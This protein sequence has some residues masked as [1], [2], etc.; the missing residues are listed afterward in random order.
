MR[1]RINLNRMVLTLLTLLL[2]W[3]LETSTGY[4]AQVDRK[5]AIA[6]ADLWYAMEINAEHTRM[7][8][9]EKAAR[10]SNIGSRDLL[11]LVSRDELRM[12][13]PKKEKVLAYIVKYK[14]NGFVVVSGE[15]R[16]K[17][18]LVFNAE[19]EFSFDPPERNY[20]RRYLEIALIG[21]FELLSKKLEDKIPVGVHANWAYL[22]AKVRESKN[23]ANASF[24]AGT[25][26]RGTYVLWDTASW[27]QP[28]PYNETV[29][30]NNGNI[31]GIPTGCNA[32]AMAI[33]MRFHE[34]PPS[35]N[36]DH[37][38]TDTV[39]YNNQLY[40]FNHYVN[41]GDQTYDWSEMPTGNVTQSNL[42]VA[43][44]MYHSG[45]CVDMNYEIPSSNTFFN[46]PNF[47]KHFRYKGTTKVTSNHEPGLIES[48]VAG[49]PVHTGNAPHAMLTTGYRD[50]PWPYF[51]INPGFNGSGNDW[52][53]LSAL[54]GGPSPITE[55]YPY[56]APQN[57]VYVREDYTG[58]ENGYPQYPF[59]TLVEGNNAVPEGGK[60][61][62]RQGTYEGNGNTPIVFSKAM[63]IIPYWGPVIME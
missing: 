24:G 14:P 33:K 18:I 61:W 55:S 6:I 60:L 36:S 32:T 8:P 51:F 59:N 22:R 63:E 35:G 62:V 52:Y 54:P 38:Y 30:A 39:L 49:L 26:G 13:L 9:Q 57:Y 12:V 31:P 23:F 43:D 42:H 1:D 27:W 3:S 44:L 21:R 11:Y 40:T 7:D 20:L 19:G 47:N 2:A 45:V 5:E 4:G 58:F 28:W 15:D 48:V 29:V 50:S 56:S 16:I 41:F 10:L 25:G 53:D 34:W 37:G 46:A 17:P